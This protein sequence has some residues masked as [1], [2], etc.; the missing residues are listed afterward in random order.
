MGARGPVPKRDEQRRRR[1]KPKTATT[2]A[3]ATPKTAA[4]KKKTTSTA[5]RPAREP[6]NGIPRADADWHPAAKRWYESLKKSGQSKFYVAS[7]WATAWIIAESLS[8]DLKPQVVGVVEETGEVVR[9][10]IPLKGASLA[11][12]LKAMTSLLATE[13][14]RRRVGIELERENRG[15]GQTDRPVTVLSDYRDRLAG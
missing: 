13:G 11:A 2:K 12:Y 1:N 5:K 15:S 4:A 6:A 10:I 7:D 9:A 8:R 14:D 3:P